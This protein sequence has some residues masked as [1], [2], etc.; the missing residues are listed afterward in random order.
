M[1]TIKIKCP[2]CGAVLGA[3]DD[4]SNANK[5]VLCPNCKVR[6]RFSD[7]RRITPVRKEEDETQI[8]LSVRDSIGYLVDEKTGRSYSLKEGRSI[9]GRMTYKTPPKADIPI[10][11]EDMGLSRAHL[12]VE[13]IK[14]RDGKYHT[15]ASN[16]S[17]AND[18]FINGSKLESGDKIGLKNNDKISS[19]KTVLR[20]VS[21]PHQVDDRTIL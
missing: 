7:F 3:A 21:E 9:I 17:N 20:F 18:T 14:G 15:Y 11:T 10:I 6:N 12:F 16:A 5:S 13:V 1:E 8:V 2:N 4:P 19:S